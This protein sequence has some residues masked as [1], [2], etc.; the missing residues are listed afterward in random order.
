MTILLD[1]SLLIDVLNRRGGRSELFRQLLQDGHTL[2]CC[3]VTIAEVHAGMR[4]HEKAA[5][6]ELLQGLEYFETP[7]R[8]AERA[9]QMKALWGRK[10]RALGL[11]DVLIAATAIEHGLALATDNRKHFPMPELKLLAIPAELH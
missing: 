2:A 10:G 8:A 4:P 5:T 7:R 1:T 3:A 6:D 11:P 9:G